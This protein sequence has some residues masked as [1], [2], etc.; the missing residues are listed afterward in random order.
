MIIDTNRRTTRVLTCLRSAG[1]TVI[2]RYYARFTRQPGK[3]LTRREAEAIVSAGLSIGIVHQASGDYAAYFSR[4]T[5]LLD[6]AY[7]RNYGATM[8]GQPAHSAI[9]FGVDYNA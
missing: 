3:R 8:I 9:Y 5:G 7:A 4:Q 6:G 1:V 2:L